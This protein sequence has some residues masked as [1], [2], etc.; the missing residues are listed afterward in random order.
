MMKKR[1]LWRKSE[2]LE[3]F[4]SSK[5]SFEVQNWT[6]ERFSETKM[7]FK[8]FWNIPGSFRLDFIPFPFYVKGKSMKILENQEKSDFN[9]NSPFGGP[10]CV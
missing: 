7:T 8:I 3:G 4:K 6:F 1:E 2:I 10:Y 9:R 5:L